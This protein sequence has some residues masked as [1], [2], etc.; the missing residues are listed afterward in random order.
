MKK[1]S[2]AAVLLARVCFAVSAQVKSQPDL[3]G[4][5]V[6]D[7]SRSD[8]TG[9]PLEDSEASIT[10][11]QTEPGI[12]MVRR[13][14]G[15]SVVVQYF[16]DGREFSHKDPFGG[17]VKSKTKWDG[18]KLVSRI[19]TRRMMS[20]RPVDLDILEEWKLSK[21]GKTLTKKVVI[22]VPKNAPD[23]VNAVP[24]PQSNQEFKKVYTRG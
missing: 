6:V 12:K 9:N 16:T 3:N 19:V 15:T 14:A 5:W 20:G 8:K 7:Q 22:I 21:D 13:Y 24:V 17:M 2:M 18:D 23:K 10:I 11:E 4:V 1:F